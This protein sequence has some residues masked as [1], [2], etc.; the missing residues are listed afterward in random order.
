MQ[1][2]K[3][4]YRPEVDGLRAIAVMG[5]IIY[6]A[7]IALGGRDLLTGGFIGVDVFF[8]ISGYLITRL[9]LAEIFETSRF[10]FAHFY[11]RRAR[12]ILPMLLTVIMA[13]IP[14]AIILFEGLPSQFIDYAKSIFWAVF[15]SSNFFFYFSATEYAAD[16]SLLSPFLHTWSLGVEEQ[17][18]IFFPFIAIFL[19]K[20]FRN[21][22]LAAFLGLFLLSLQFADLM[23]T[24]QTD[25]NFYLPMSRF[26]ELLVGSMI[27]YIELKHGRLKNDIVNAVAPVLGIYMIAWAL[28]SFTDD[29]PHP[30]FLTFIPVA[31][32]ALVILFSSRGDLTGQILGS[33]LFVGVGLI[34]YSAYLWHY[35]LFAFARIANPSL[36]TVE[37]IGLIIFTLILSVL[38]YFFI[39]QPFRQRRLIS[40]KMLAS[41]VTASLLALFISVSLFYPDI[42]KFERQ[43]QSDP[44]LVLDKGGYLKAWTE[45]K[46]G[47]GTTEFEHPSRKKLLIV[48]DSHATDIYSALQQNA[49]LFPA[50]DFAIVHAD[51][52]TPR[53]S[54]YEVF[55]FHLN[56]VQQSKHECEG[57]SFSTIYEKYQEADAIMFATHWLQ[58]ELHYLPG[59]IR[60]IHADGK[61]VILVSN[62]LEIRDQKRPIRAFIEQN[63]RFP[64]EAETTGIGK[65]IYDFLKSDTHVADINL[66]LKKIS[67]DFSLRYLVKHDLFCSDYAKECMVF[68]PANDIIHWD[69]AHYTVGGAKFIGERM[70]EMNWLEGGLDVIGS[71]ESGSSDG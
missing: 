68:T 15:F 54:H 65:T 67:E 34:S 7:E 47:L 30:G 32:T 22:L 11:E 57:T 6:H 26:W 64:N 29:T 71:S 69:Y 13:S 10:S 36:G 23:S 44:T 52:P 61:E 4:N 1:S 59:T 9:I 31:G 35:P 2:S 45:F 24:R 37:K 17:F 62:N 50:Y 39:E 20:F 16:S 51:R 53:S 60:K 3:I 12:R 5:V 46:I 27:A 19:H 18:Y 14:F 42:T 43:A 63:G 58:Q 70:A 28:F 38:S 56:F 55:C 21:H 48:G 40:V 33:R 8:V 49:E 25:L 66:G 41:A